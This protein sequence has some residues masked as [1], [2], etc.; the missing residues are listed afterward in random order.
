MAA[1][2]SCMNSSA[3]LVHDSEDRRKFASSVPKVQ[4]VPLTLGCIGRA[5]IR[6]LLFS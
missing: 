3:K 5:A 6:T 2:V 4:R 1:Q